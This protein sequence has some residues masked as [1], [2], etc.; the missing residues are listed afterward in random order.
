MPSPDQIVLSKGENRM[1][2][3]VFVICVLLLTA[4]FA[5]AQAMPQG[6]GQNPS[7]TNSNNPAQPQNPNAQQPNQNPDQQPSGAITQDQSRS[8][9]A[10]ANATP[11]KTDDDTLKRQ[12]H[13]QLASNPDLANVQVDVKDG[14][15]MLTGSVAKK[16][17]RSQARDL[18]KAVPGVRS[19]KEHLS[20][21]AAVSTSAS[22]ATPSPTTG[23][24]MPQS[25]EAGAAAATSGAAQAAKSGDQEQ[26]KGESIPSAAPSN[27]QTTLS[28]QPPVSSSQ[29]T[30]SPAQTT[31]QSSSQ[32]AISPEQAQGQIMT[33]LRTQLPSAAN[34]ISVQ[35]N[36]NQLVLVGSVNSDQDKQRAEEIARSAAANQMVINNITVKGPGEASAASS[37]SQSAA[38]AQPSA[39]ATANL[40][41]SSAAGAAHQ[42][43]S[44]TANLPQAPSQSTA[45]GSTAASQS[46][47]QP[48]PGVAGQSNLPQSSTTETGA[49]AGVNS[50]ATTQLQSQ[51]QKALQNE[52]SLAN[53]NVQA[54]VSGDSIELTGTVE[55]GKDKQTAKRIAQSFAGNRKVVDHIKVTGKG[56]KSENEKNPSAV[57]PKL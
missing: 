8:K 17:D 3:S 42:S 29:S 28:P 40:P 44:S 9:P 20:I 6:T 39:G 37:S 41:Q 13:E 43:T 34:S 53:S 35:V 23:N 14:R 15:V 55:T 2:R 10:T 18:A 46:T 32:A 5:V 48:Q 36:N 4:A 19:V 7:P 45:T 38:G 27:P 22:A 51:I 49:Q 47:T 52:P 56:M 31:T 24:A 54:N 1:K 57:N 50:D 21:S 12:V 33:A 25:G 16:D 30:Q 11:E 26:P